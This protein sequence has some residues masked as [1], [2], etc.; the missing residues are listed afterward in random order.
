MSTRTRSPGTSS[1]SFARRAS[2]RQASLRSRGRGRQ[3]S[4]VIGG[5]VPDGAEERTARSKRH[6][7]SRRVSPPNVTR[8][9]YAVQMRPSGSCTNT[10]LYPSAGGAAVARTAGS[11]S[12]IASSASPMF[13]G[14]GHVGSG[15]PEKTYAP[16]I[17]PVSLVD[18]D[19]AM[20]D[21]HE[22]TELRVRTA[23]GR[24]RIRDRHAGVVDVG[25]GRAG[26]IVAALQLANWSGGSVGAARWPLF[27][28][29]L[30]LLVA[31]LANRP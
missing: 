24:A 23:V 15:R 12:Q 8:A 25:H 18:L 30:L 3:S 6:S 27:V 13:G 14:I 19:V 2:R 26:A 20:H 4:A 22:R 16:A 28:A 31:A 21:D 9:W 7:W 29:R 17:Q 5:S 1:S 11:N 10:P